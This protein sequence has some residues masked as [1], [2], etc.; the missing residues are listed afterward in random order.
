[1]AYVDTVKQWFESGDKP[2]Q[3]QFYQWMAYQRW[4]DE[5]ITSTDLDPTLLTIING[6]TRTILLSGGV[7]VWKA[8]AG[9]LIEK[10]FVGKS[11][12]AAIGVPV[13]HV[14]IGTTVGGAELLE[15][16]V[17]TANIQNGILGCD[18]YAGVDTFIYFTVTVGGVDATDFIIKIY[19]S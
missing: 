16:D 17:D 6:F 7:V 9:T 5:L 12:P 2:T 14:K 15:A 19:K 4:K 18:F 3:G 11:D 10:F 1:M 8:K 13:Y